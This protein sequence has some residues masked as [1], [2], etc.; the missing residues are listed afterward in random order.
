MPSDPGERDEFIQLSEFVSEFPW[1]K[2]KSRKEKESKAWKFLPIC[3]R[4]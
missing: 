2:G 1:K 4:G 3:G